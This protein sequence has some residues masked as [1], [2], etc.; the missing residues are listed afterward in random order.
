MEY[1]DPCN[2]RTAQGVFRAQYREKGRKMREV[3]GMPPMLF[4]LADLEFFVRGT[5]G[6]VHAS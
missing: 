2:R 6:I 4:C 3:G 5:D 1:W